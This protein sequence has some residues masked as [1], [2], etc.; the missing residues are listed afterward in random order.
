MNMGKL[1]DGGKGE[2][3]GLWMGSTPIRRR[4]CLVGMLGLLPVQVRVAAEE[5]FV[6]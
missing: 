2:N 4:H 6:P 3:L 5:A 1:T